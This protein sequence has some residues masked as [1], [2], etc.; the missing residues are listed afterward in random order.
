MEV[1]AR[2]DKIQYEY[3]DLILGP[4]PG[5]HVCITCK[6]TVTRTK[7]TECSPCRRFRSGDLPLKQKEH[8]MKKFLDKAVENGVIPPYTLHDRSIAQRLDPI[9]FG[10][11]R[12]DWVW[13]LSDR[14]IVLECDEHQH[15]GK[16]YSCERRRELQICNVAGKLPVFFIRFNPDTFKTG[17][18]SCRVNVNGESVVERHKAVVVAIENAVAHVSPTGLTFHK[19]FFDCECVGENGVHPCSFQH[20]SHYADHESFLKHF[21]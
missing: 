2:R 9:L 6:L 5:S 11:S 18:K 20:T 19:L 1:R 8:A 3:Y 15:S 13:I 14:W 4:F 16:Q 21:Q 7:Q 12:P 10:A 17:S